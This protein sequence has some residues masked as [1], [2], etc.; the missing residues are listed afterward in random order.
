[1]KPLKEIRTLKKN[2]H[3]LNGNKNNSPINFKFQVSFKAFPKGYKNTFNLHLLSAFCAQATPF[4]HLATCY[5]TW[6]M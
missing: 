5:V 3:A 6:P 4:D 2:K 1:M